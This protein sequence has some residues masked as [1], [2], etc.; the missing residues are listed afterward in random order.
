M[1]QFRESKKAPLE[2]SLS[3]TVECGLDSS[4]LW[5]NWNLLS[6]SSAIPALTQGGECF[7]FSLQNEC[8]VGN[9]WSSF[10]PLFI[11]RRIRKMQLHFFP[12][13]YFLFYSKLFFMNIPLQTNNEYLTSNSFSSR[14][15]F[16]FLFARSVAIQNYQHFVLVDFPFKI[17][18][19]K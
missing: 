4:I 5:W 12:H 8:V 9:K 1:S 3:V 10:W 13:S 2:Y 14:R 7:S 15:V 6:V 19:V 16:G 17:E 18:Q 11:A